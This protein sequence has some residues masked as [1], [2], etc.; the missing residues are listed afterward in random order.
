MNFAFLAS[1]AWLFTTPEKA[2]EK[3]L[4]PKENIVNGGIYILQSE[5]DASV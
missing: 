5:A 2:A 4:Y 1:L 3:G